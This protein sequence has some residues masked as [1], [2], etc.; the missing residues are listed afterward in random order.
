MQQF[1]ISSRL[2]SPLSAHCPNTFQFA[3]ISLFLSSKLPGRRNCERLYNFRH[4]NSHLS[5]RGSCVSQ[6]TLITAASSSKEG[7]ISWDQC[8]HSCFGLPFKGSNC[9]REILF[10]SSVV[11]SDRLRTRPIARAGGG[12]CEDIA[13]VYR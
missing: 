5:Y 7:A 10:R 6:S 1:G 11:R 8:S 12:F 13:S 4:G 9:T 3:S 2:E